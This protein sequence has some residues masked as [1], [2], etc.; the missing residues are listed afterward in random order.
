M[1]LKTITFIIYLSLCK[2]KY[3]N[4]DFQI[5]FTNT[6]FAA[7]NSIYCQKCIKLFG[8]V[9]KIVILYNNVGERRGDS[10]GNQPAHVAAACWPGIV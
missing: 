2:D 1:A 8:I 6:T 3:K 4:R 7:I 10:D 9:E 5:Y